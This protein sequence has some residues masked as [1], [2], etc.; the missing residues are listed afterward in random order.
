MY[1]AIC[2]MLLNLVLSMII[3]YDL[4][5]GCQLNYGLMN[6]LTL[7]IF[8]PPENVLR[9]MVGLLMGMRMMNLNEGQ[10][11]WLWEWEWSGVGTEFFSSARTRW[12]L[13]IITVLEI[14]IMKK[15]DL[16]VDCLFYLKSRMVLG[17]GAEGHKLCFL[18]KYYFIHFKSIEKKSW[19]SSKMGV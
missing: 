6:W 19:V 17:L 11:E 13:D 8:Y 4:Y 16:L 18:Y 3:L 2:F 15:K 5:I 1:K 14:E 9:M 12:H 7:L 10:G